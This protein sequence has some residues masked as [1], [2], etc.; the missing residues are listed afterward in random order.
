VV[1]LVFSRATGHTA[2]A[3]DKIID[4]QTEKAF[5]VMF[6]K[7]KEFSC[8]CGLTEDLLQNSGSS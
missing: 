7:A 8:E 4:M 5:D 6:H 2:A 1:D 3:Q